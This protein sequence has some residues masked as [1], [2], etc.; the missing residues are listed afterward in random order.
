MDPLVTFTLNNKI[1]C[2]SKWSEFMTSMCYSSSLSFTLAKS[3]HWIPSTL[4]SYTLT[5][6]YTL[7]CGSERDEEGGRREGGGSEERVIAS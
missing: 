1:V 3:S 7:T 6:S 5:S 4:G 2:I